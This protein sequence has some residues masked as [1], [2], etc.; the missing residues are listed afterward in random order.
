MFFVVHSNNSFN[1]PV[2]L[3]KYIV[4]VVIIVINE[5]SRQVSKSVFSEAD[6][7]LFCE[8]NW[9]GKNLKQNE[10][11]SDGAE[12]KHKDNNKDLSHLW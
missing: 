5:C 12:S 9:T 3:I 1:F 6:W 10:A 7:F 2:G 8:K 11:Q 4:A